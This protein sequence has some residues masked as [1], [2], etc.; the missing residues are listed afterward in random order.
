MPNYWDT[1]GNVA[2]G[3]GNTLNPFDGGKGYADAQY[4]PPAQTNTQTWVPWAPQTQQPSTLLAR[5]QDYGYNNYVPPAKAA[6]FDVAGTYASAYNQAATSQNPLYDKYLN[7]F[8]AN[9]SNDMAAKQ[10]LN[11]ETQTNYDT[12]LKNTQ[13]AN[14]LTG[15]RTSADVALKEGQIAENADQFQTDSG[16]KFA[17]D[18]IQQARDQAKAGGTGGLS[19]QKTEGMQASRNIQEDRQVQQFDTQRVAQELIKARTFEDLATSSRLASEKTAT[20]KAS[21]QFDLDNYIQASKLNEEKYRLTDQENR[22]KA[23]IEER[24]RVASENYQNWL[25]TLSDPVRI[26]T[27]AKYN[28]SF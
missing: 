11:T 5:P 6:N 21:A 24:N 27:A 4:K 14:A 1:A 7:N 17:I 2:R 13:E 18:R 19:G 28:G 22:N 20:G 15:T 12:A 3:I 25:R 10:H 23:I 9:Q 26:A 8:L 16:T